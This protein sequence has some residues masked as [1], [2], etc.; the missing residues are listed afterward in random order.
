[1]FFRTRIRAAGLIAVIFL[2]P[3]LL[4]VSALQK[5]AHAQATPPAPAPQIADNDLNR[6]FHYFQTRDVMLNISLDQHR[7]Y[8]F[9]TR[10]GGKWVQATAPAGTTF[11]VSTIA[12]ANSV[13]VAQAGNR[14]YGFAPGTGTL[15]SVELPS[16]EPVQLSVSEDVAC[17]Q[18]GNREYAFSGLV[19]HWD[20]VQLPTSDK[21]DY[22]VATGLAMVHY[23]SQMW[24]YSAAAGKWQMIDTAVQ[25]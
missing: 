8:G 21:L 4:C 7:I 10:T 23:K 19:G 24:A 22:E 14:V 11:D 9:S 15:E 3:G 25:P 20:T 16:S 1:M 12:L 17:F 5:W 18:A 2:L 6:Y 13:A